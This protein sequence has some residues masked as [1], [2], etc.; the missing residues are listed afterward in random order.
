MVGLILATVGTL[1]AVV[2]A[3]IAAYQVYLSRFSLGVDLT[4]RMDERFESPEFLKKRCGAAHAVKQQRGSDF[5]PVLD[6]FETLG[7]LTRRGAL[8]EEFVYSTFFYWLHGYVSKCGAFIAEQFLHCGPNH[9][10]ALA[11]VR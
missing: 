7:L 9:L 4:F 1:A 8:D 2:A 11:Q 6:F 3:L 5:E 10:G